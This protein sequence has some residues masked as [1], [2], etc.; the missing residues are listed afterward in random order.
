V[1]TVC[2]VVVVYCLFQFSEGGRCQSAEDQLSGP[3]SVWGHDMEGHD[4]LFS[5]DMERND[6]QMSIIELTEVTVCLHFCF[7]S[8]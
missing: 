2:C 4:K 5:P 6:S 8:H 1:S 3:Q 7:L